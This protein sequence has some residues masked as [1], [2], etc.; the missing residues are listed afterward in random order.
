M[1]HARLST[2]VRLSI[3]VVFVI[4]VAAL[5]RFPTATA[6]TSIVVA[7]ILDVPRS[8]VNV[9]VLTGTQGF[10]WRGIVSM[11]NNLAGVQSCN[12]DPIRCGPGTTVTLG[13]LNLDTSSFVTFE[14]RS[15]LTGCSSPARP[16]LTMR[17][18][19]SVVLPPLAPTATVTAPFELSGRLFG[20]PEGGVTF[21]GAGTATYFLHSPGTPGFPDSWA[22]DRVVLRLAS[23]LPE[24][25][26]SVDVGAVGREG[27]TQV[28][29]SSPVG[30]G[31]TVR[32][33]GADIWGTEDAF[34]FVPAYPNGDTIIARVDSLE[35][36]DPY[37][38]AGVM[39]RQSFDA[40]SPHVL[41]AVKPDGGIELLS[42]AAQSGATSLVAYADPAA[43]PVWLKLTVGSA[44]IASLS[45][46]GQTWHTVGTVPAFPSSFGLATST[47]LLGLATTSHQHAALTQATFSDVVISGSVPPNMALPLG[48]TARDIGAVSQVGSATANGSV[49]SVR[50]SGQDIWGTSDQFHYVYRFLQGNGEMTARVIEPAEHQ[51]VGEGGHHDP[52]VDIAGRLPARVPGREARWR[53]RTARARRRRAADLPGRR[54]LCQPSPYGCA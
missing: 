39:I 21:F 4:G 27:H 30:L 50:T 1:P 31:F 36:T 8:G 2:S 22:I 16:C 13:N 38:K 3:A 7:G 17:L 33:A 48:L 20:L 41:L 15:Y 19:G 23:P 46:D 51:S 12:D 52:R 6:Q 11:R 24:P 37:A 42:R 10:S 54:R 9:A 34:Q 14:G 45:R 26:T 25:W 47:N 53:H 43:F 18:S 40:S 29:S 35:N 44:I 28:D 32:G 5:T 49:V